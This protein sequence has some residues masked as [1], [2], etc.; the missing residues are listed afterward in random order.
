MPRET[1]QDGN[2]TP[3]NHEP[4]GH[5]YQIYSVDRINNG[6]DKPHDIAIVYLQTAVPKTV[7][8]QYLPI[9]TGNPYHEVTTGQ[10]A[11]PGYIAGFGLTAAS[12]TDEHAGGQEDGNR[13]F[14]DA[15][16]HIR[17]HED[18]CDKAIFEGSCNNDWQWEANRIDN[19]QPEEGDSGGPLILTETEPYIHLVVAG[20]DSGWVK[21][22]G[23]TSRTVWAPTG[24]PGGTNNGK[25]ILDHMGG[26][27]DG[28]GIP[29]NIDNC[30]S[31]RC[32]ND[33]DLSRCNNPDQAD[34]DGDGVGDTCDNC[35]PAWCKEL[36]TRYGTPTA[37][38]GMYC[39][40]P[41]QEDWDNDGLGNTCDLCPESGADKDNPLADAD[42]DGV[43]DVCDT[44][45]KRVG[46]QGCN[47]SADCHNGYCIAGTGIIGG[48]CSKLT[49]SD[50]D[51]IPDGC[52]D[53]NGVKSPDGT[54]SNDIAEQREQDLDPTTKTLPDACDPVPI[55]RF[56]ERDPIAIDPKDVDKL[57]PGD[58]QGPDD[59][60]V[61]EPNRWL[62]AELTDPAKVQSV[63]RQVVYRMCNCFDQFGT[64]L[65][66][67]QCVTD[68]PTLCPDSAPLTDAARWR[69]PTLVNSGGS[70]I[71]DSTG[72]TQIPEGYS[73]GNE[74]T[75]Q[76]VTWRWRDDRK[77]GFPGEGNCFVGGPL[78]CKAHVALMTR[79]V[80]TLPGPYAST[81]EQNHTL[82]DV[83]HT[84]TTPPANII[85]SYPGAPSQPGNH[86]A[87]VAWVTPDYL[88]DPPYL[89][90][91]NLFPHPEPIA[92]QPSGDIVAFASADRTLNITSY[93]DDF[94]RNL[95][96]ADA[97]WLTAV[98][99]F[100]V[101]RK[102]HSFEVEL[103]IHVALLARDYAGAP[104]VPI[105]IRSDGVRFGFNSGDA[106]DPPPVLHNVHGAYSAVEG[107][108]YMVGGTLD[109]GLPGNGIWRYSFNTGD[110]HLIDIGGGYVP[111]SRVL[112]VGYDISGRHL[113]VLD[114]DDDDVR[115]PKQRY[116]R[117]YRI[118]LDQQTS[119]LLALFH[120]HDAGNVDAIAVMPDGMLALVKGHGHA[121]SVWRV[122]G[123]GDHAQFQGVLAGSGEVLDG[124]VMGE[125]RLYLPVSRGGKV[126]VVAL[127]SERFHGGA[128]CKSL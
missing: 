68:T 57:V 16:S 88:P 62:G 115:Q 19:P 76:T 32:A 94:T 82:G 31:W 18:P 6:S 74:T 95:L 4:R 100:D 8:N 114:V 26:D 101:A 9:A 51:G 27:P 59:V 116:A 83:Y 66:V 52:D 20:V 69:I 89:G 87:P 11:R 61:I 1:A 44:C 17:V 10:L 3:V 40:N 120:Y 35:P 71:L 103:G 90:F 7:V 5:S 117:L 85:P 106:V 91:T 56:K 65:P 93:F 92:Q 127:G 79:T 15:A 28:D 72:T 45:D 53:C 104:P 78:D 24:S 81:R 49:D 60:A 96:G 73:T 23:G 30:P 112:S 37:P 48:R 25:W 75:S 54:N 113:Y 97:L 38:F 42:G 67:S 98:E 36:A 123:R 63:E 34:L 108:V 43:G 47:T 33:P 122:D 125:D 46:Y 84:V 99:P 118:D 107:N 110:W 64:P 121:W 109:S 22:A 126:D 119:I 2:H 41:G 80:K 77:S 111:S 86:G 50:D 124:P 39:K 12:E 55:E 102:Y 29:E 21:D 58:E 105:S 70:P 128:S 13:R 14:G